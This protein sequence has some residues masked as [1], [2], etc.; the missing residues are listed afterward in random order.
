MQSNLKNYLLATLILISSAF[1]AKFAPTIYHIWENSPE[2]EMNEVFFIVASIFLL[3]TVA[4]YS[5][6]ALKLPSFVLA[7]AFG[8]AAKP[9]LNP[10][11]IHGEV[12]AILVSMGAT[13]ILFG[14][15]LET[16]FK[17]FKRLFFKI[18]S[19][20]FVG[21]V[22]TAWLFSQAVFYLSSWMG[23]PLSMQT[24]VILGAL[25]AS[26]DPAAII[27]LLKNLRFKNRFIK[28]LVI[29]ESAVTDVS[30]TLLTIAFLSVI[31]SGISYPS[32][33]AWYG[34][35]FSM[36]SGLVLGK[37]ILFGVGA[38]IFGYILLRLL[39]FRKNRCNR[40]FEA[41]SAYFLFVPI[42]IFTIALSFGGSGY[43]AAFIAGLI[44]SLNE[45]MKATENFFNFLVDGF[46][47]P[48]VFIFLGALV[49]IHGLLDYAA[50]GLLSALVFMLIIR[51][52]AVMIS[53]SFWLRFG[54]DRLSFKDLLFVSLVRETGAIPAVLLTTV[55]G[56]G[57]TGVEG[58]V[59]IGM[60]VILST[61]IIEPVITPWAAR[62]L[63][64]AKEMKD[65]KNIE[66]I[67]TG[68]ISI[69][70][71]RGESFTKRL[72]FV[73]EWTA[74]N[75]SSKQVILLSCPEDKYS[76]DEE[77]RINELA[78]NQFNAINLD[79]QSKGLDKINFSILS[80][81][82][83]LQDNLQ[84][85]CKE[86]GCKSVIFV[87]RKMLDFRFEDVKHLGAPIFF[88]E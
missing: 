48:A 13:F 73:A 62:K 86:N 84:L 31:T 11:M 44:F 55:I 33:N 21:L 19:L 26:T 51:P 58:L 54:R 64:V 70:G 2:G 27:P 6:R 35:I 60:W 68:A 47:K 30:G 38:G 59:E 34:S 49:D 88:L 10:V 83:F 20:S 67:P 18:S 87:G 61:L 82:G 36:E 12:L 8:L 9:I 29:S 57:L 75:L 63:G 22:I 79:L 17:N 23:Q 71:T 3:S 52:I 14:G 65:E 24:A 43:L 80:R 32:I 85:L 76:A 39:H 74:A 53:L 50:L 16:P 41:D 77:K 7:I 5:S 72:P 46:F 1:L 78:V 42:I 66:K 56:M 69:L 15:G 37:Q 81:E 40:E 28:N 45:K 4:F 25:L